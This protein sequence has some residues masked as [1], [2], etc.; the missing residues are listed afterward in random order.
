MRRGSHPS[1]FAER[2]N[3]QRRA[4]QYVRMST[5]HQKYSIANQLTAIAEYAAA[6]YISIVKTYE[7]PG[8]SGLGLEW[9]K[10]LRTLIGDV[11]GGQSD[12]DTILV[13]DVSRWGR[14][15]D[16][17]ESAYYEFICK[18]AGV[19][20]HYCA[21]QFDNND[22][23]LT[24]SVL[25]S[26]KRAMAG[27][28]SRELS[29]KIFAS[30]IRITSLGFKAGG[31]AGYGFRRYIV[32]QHGNH[33]GELRAGDRK[34][35]QSDHVV[36]VPGSKHEIEI[37]QR[38]YRLFVND[39]LTEKDIADTLN[40][41]GLRNELGCA[42]TGPKIHGILTKEKYIG[43]YVFNRTTQKL[44]TKPVSNPPE[45]WIRRV[46]AFEPM[47][48]TE[49][50][51]AARKKIEARVCRLTDVEMVA[52]L[53][54]AFH[55]HGALS[56]SLIDADE[57]TPSSF[58]YR[59][60]F[61]SL[62]RAWELAGYRP[63][64]NSENL[65]TRPHFRSIVSDVVAAIIQNVESSGGTAKFDRKRRVL[66]INDELTASIQPIYCNTYRSRTA[67]W[68]VRPT[69]NPKADIV[70]CV[71]MNESNTDIVDYFVLPRTE[72]REKFVL[73]YRDNRFEID[74]YRYRTLNTFFDICS[75]QP[76][77]S[78]LKR[79]SSL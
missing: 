64:Y 3:V 14:F 10:G 18:Q 78:E 13:Y 48:S 72:F 68:R 58:L 16:V 69:A 51:E 46:G 30:Q 25:K 59:R 24:A 45:M 32:D 41:E 73:L 53:K 37:V 43:N 34:G 52:R 33:K 67:R 55:R 50:F 77:G 11:K 76:V 8:K 29:V 2:V 31:Q 61:G 6:R 39:D 75:R 66:T 74:A 36:L 54:E 23:S 15:Q 57:N 26:I 5:D 38:I 65:Q 1:D 40:R 44:R 56:G 70:I 4:A 49:L 62:V 63:K 12:F 19:A 22:G 71:R 47:V 28:Y 27:E 42:W 21:E 20:V 7:D 35:F 9:R 60:R 17:D 79:S